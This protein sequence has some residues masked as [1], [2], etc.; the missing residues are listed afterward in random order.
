MRNT[1]KNLKIVAVSAFVVTATSP[2]SAS[3]VTP[4]HVYRAAEAVFLTLEQFHDASFSTFEVPNFE[5]NDRKPRHVLQ[6][7]QEVN[8]KV[9]E[10]RWL[11]GLPRKPISALPVRDVKPKHVMTAVDA[12]LLDLQELQSIFGVVVDGAPELR[13]SIT[14][15]DVYKQLAI[16]SNSLDALGIPAVVP[17]NVYLV[18]LTVLEDLRSVVSH[19]KGGAT[20]TTLLPSKGRSPAD[21]YARTYALLEKIKVLSDREGF[22][23]PGGISMPQKKGGKIVP[24]D[25]MGMLNIILAE[26]GA[27]KLVTGV[28]TPTRFADQQS[29]KTPSDVYDSILEAE[30]LVD[31]LLVTRS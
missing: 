10:L 9:Q 20:S 24:A 1:L 22:K 23:I 21:V 30:Q 27:L 17:N 14:P 12:I 28:T 15:T 4:A 19:V 7:S 5:I 3:D 11:Y 31:S 6:A 2:V 16:I 8:F 13:D 29:G 26:I 25:V 18:A